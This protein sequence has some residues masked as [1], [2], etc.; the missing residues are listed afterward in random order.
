M[1][2]VTRSGSS[3]LYFGGEGLHACVAWG[4]SQV[5]VLSAIARSR[6]KQQ[7]IFTRVDPVGGLRGA[8]APLPS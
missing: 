6:C 3:T 8:P 5:D 4:V 1:N 2:S 7:V